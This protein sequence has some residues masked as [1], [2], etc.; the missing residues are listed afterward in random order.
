[1]ILLSNVLMSTLGADAEKSVRGRKN[2]NIHSS[3]QDFCQRFINAIRIASYIRSHRHTVSGKRELLVALKGS[4]SLLTFDE[5]GNF[6][7][8]VCFGSEKYAGSSCPNIGLEIPPD[9]W[10]TVIASEENS[11]LLEVKE[12]PFIASEAKEFASWAPQEGSDGAAVF[13]ANYHKFSKSNPS[14]F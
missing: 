12:G 6:I 9:V 1:M 5:H 3:H 11:I 8:N 14:L 4:F 7:D 13:L 10:H 2:L